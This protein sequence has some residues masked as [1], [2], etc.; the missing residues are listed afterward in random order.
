MLRVVICR[1]KMAL[2]QVS[3]DVVALVEKLLRIGSWR[4][5]YGLV[6]CSCDPNIVWLSV[7]VVHRVAVNFRA[8]FLLD[9]DGG[10]L[11]LLEGDRIVCRASEVDACHVLWVE[12][13][14]VIPDHG[15]Q[16]RVHRLLSCACPLH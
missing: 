5:R 13:L 3:T 2:L 1:H 6:E 15:I 16:I 9:E 7:R 14:R 11:G 12:V 8:G 10:I 4:L